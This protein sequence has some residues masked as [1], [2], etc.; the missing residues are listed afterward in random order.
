[1]AS[2]RVYLRHPQERILPGIV[3]WITD[4]RAI[5][6][7][8]IAWTDWEID[9]EE[10]DKAEEAISR[11]LKIDPHY[12]PA[13]LLTVQI[14][15][16]QKR[17]A[18][19]IETARQVIE[20]GPEAEPGLYLQLGRI[21]AESGRTDEGLAYLGRLEGDHPQM[22]EIHSALGTIRLKRQE[23]D[24]A[25]KELLEALRLNPALGDPLTE[26]HKIYQGTER[27]L[28]LE[29][30]V[31]KGLAINE[32]SVIHHNWMGFIHEWKKELP[33]AEAEFHRAVELDPDDAAT[34]A[35]LGALYGRSGRLDDAVTVLSRAVAKEPDNKEAWV[36]LGAAQGRLRRPKEAIAALETARSKGVR[37]TTLYNALALAYLQDHRRDKALE[38][39][40]E[41]LAIDPDQ[42]DAKDLLSAVG[43]S[44]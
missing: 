19:A 13:L 35:N 37:T 22:A 40:K 16:E 43:G 17:Y 33:Q 36:N 7:T 11:A 10:Y 28:S 14:N 24:A 3:S 6:A 5:L 2:H 39:L 38:Y 4:V 26:L 42:K 30:L 31:R 15:T 12:T 21:Y 9:S 41:S 18:P 27:V 1:M 20:A 32:K 44:S 23:S 25:E 8:K 29:P 34:L